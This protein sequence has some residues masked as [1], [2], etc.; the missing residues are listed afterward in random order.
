M[1]Q[2]FISAQAH[3]NVIGVHKIDKFWQIELGEQDQMD[4]MST[5]HYSS[6]FKDYDPLFDNFE[7][8]AHRAVGYVDLQNEELYTLDEGRIKFQASDD[9]M[10]EADAN[11]TGEVE[12][13]HLVVTPKRAVSPYHFSVVLHPNDSLPQII[14]TDILEESFS[15]FYIFA[16]QNLVLGFDSLCAGSEV[17]Q[18]HIEGLLLGIELDIPALPLEGAS[19][20]EAFTC[21]LRNKEVDAVHICSK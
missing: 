16:G 20:E 6:L 1:E 8:L 5:P 14:G 17:N 4:E 3:V 11:E 18:L 9:F 7:R 19:F 21:G 15:L 13:G 12:I 2:M 10:D